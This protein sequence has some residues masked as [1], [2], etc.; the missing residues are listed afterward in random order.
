MVLLISIN[1]TE[2]YTNPEAD[3]ATC[4]LRR[5]GFDVDI[6]YC[7]DI[8][9]KNSIIQSLTNQYDL[10]GVLVQKPT[11]KEGYLAGVDIAKAAA[12]EKG[13]VFA[14]GT[15][16][17]NN[18][19]EILQNDS[20]E[21]VIL[22]NYVENV[23]LLAKSVA[24]NNTVPRI[25]SIA[26]RDNIG[27]T[28]PYVSENVYDV[29]YDYYCKDSVEKNRTKIHWMQLKNNV[30]PNRCSFCE[31]PNG[32][33]AVRNFENVYREIKTVA[34]MGVQK[35]FFKDPDLFF[36]H[37][38]EYRKLLKRIF[39]QIKQDNLQL[40][41]TCFCRSSTLKDNAQ[42]NELLS[43]M[44][45]GG[46]TTV[47]V[48]L[49]GGNEHDLKLYNKGTNIAK[50]YETLS[51]LQKNNI[52]PIPGFIN[53]NPYSTL[54]TLGL[55]YKFLTSIRCASHYVYCNSILKV[56]KGTTIYERLKQDG[57]LKDGEQIHGAI[58]YAFQDSATEKI[59]NFFVQNGSQ[60]KCV[61]SAAHYLKI[62]YCDCKFLYPEVEEMF[63]SAIAYLEHKSFEAIQQFFALVYEQNDLVA[64][65]NALTTYVD[66]MKDISEQ[67][68]VISQSLQAR[69]PVRIV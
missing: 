45:S 61:K 31:N 69:F 7:H 39:T 22:G 33:I 64:A 8:S 12:S 44:Y 19:K 51:L 36:P 13:I 5:E 59:Y 20:V 27:A 26:C 6:V 49:D 32:K 54:E 56:Y 53:I 3:Q 34:E 38:A 58:P 10:I 67:C 17:T 47:F 4:Q 65:Q 60:L 14:A 35:F 23:V 2:L 40:V 29:C 66:T 52:L 46:L 9:K 63:G 50:H 28:Q 43:I 21:Y 11:F 1:E 62:Q 30:C 57:L 18:Y 41:F 24:N 48:G 37:T 15:F 55:N 42:D 16:A 25:S 68:E